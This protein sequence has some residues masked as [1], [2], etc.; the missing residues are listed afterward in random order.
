MGSV[1]VV[2]LLFVV[3]AAIIIRLIATSHREANQKE[4]VDISYG[5]IN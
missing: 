4:H 5:L 2:L 1:V 3:A